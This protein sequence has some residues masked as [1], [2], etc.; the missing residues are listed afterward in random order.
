MGVEMHWLVL[1]LAASFVFVLL[2][3]KPLGVVI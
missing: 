3:R 2:L 1:Y